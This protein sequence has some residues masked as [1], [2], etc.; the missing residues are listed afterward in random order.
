MTRRTN[1][2][3]PGWSD[4]LQALARN[5]VFTTN[6]VVGLKRRRSRDWCRLPPRCCWKCLC[7]V[8]GLISA[9]KMILCS[10]GAFLCFISVTV[11]LFI[12][13]RLVEL[14]TAHAWKT[15]LPYFASSVRVPF[16]RNKAHLFIFLPINLCSFKDKL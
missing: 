12:T 14:L 15:Y 4:S 2:L 11:S 13:L 1:T 10:T 7:R 3:D 16:K 5:Y 9:A 6:H 8:S